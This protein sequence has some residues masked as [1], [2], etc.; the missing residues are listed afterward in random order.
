MRSAFGSSPR[1]I[2]A[3]SRPAIDETY[4][5]RGLN[6]ISPDQIMPKGESPYTINSRM[7]SREDDTVRV[8]TETRKGP[9]VNSTPVGQ[10]LNV[11]DTGTVLSDIGF[12]PTKWYA[13]PFTPNAAGVL[14]QID[15]YIHNSNGAAGPVIVEIYTNDSGNP[16]TLLAQ[17]SVRTSSMLPTFQYLPVYFIDAPTLANGTQYWIVVHT[18]TEGQGQYYLGQTAVSGGLQSTNSGGSWTSGSTFRYKSYLSTGGLIKGFTRRSPF[19]KAYRNL[20]AL[21]TNLYSVPDN[22]ATPVLI[23]SDIGST[24]TKVRFDQINDLTFYA[25]GVKPLKQWDGTNAPSAV[26]NLTGTPSNVVAWKNRL[27]VLKDG[28]R[29]EFSD[30]FDFV[31]WPSVNFFYVGNPKSPDPMT[32]WVVFQDNLII[33]TRETKYILSGSD[34]SSFTVQQAVGTKGAVSQEVLAVD[35]NYVYFLAPDGTVNRF[36]GISDELI[37]DK[38]QPELSTIQDLETASLAIHKNNVRLY[39]SKA[40]NVQVDRCV[41]FD[42]VF[43]QWFLDTGKAVMGAMSVVI[44]NVPKLVEFSSRAGW[45]LYGEEADSD[46]GKAIDFKYWTPYK[47]YGTGSS[48]KRIKRFRPVLRASQARYSM[49][50]GVDFNFTNKPKLNDYLVS[51]EG[52]TWGGGSLWG[53]GADVTW[54]STSLVDN[55]TQAS[56]RAEHIQYRFEKKGVDTP[57]EIYGYIILYKEGRPR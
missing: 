49:K 34:L 3:S 25:D 4:D 13:R 55:P 20:F 30:L 9:I 18:Q 11:Q 12:T 36:N 35:R 19:D 44:G 7:Y 6:M 56:G 10:T 32:G 23:D 51:G 52:E 57:I 17:S 37:S 16:K 31:T 53:Q 46:L 47:A 5:L 28:L 39:Y 1:R 21:G 26:Q 38:M 42:S 15:L 24:A 8:A 43:Q 40:P 22:P 33:F 45:I 29:V 48:K 54:G 2:I 27:F 50:V 41:V 14:T